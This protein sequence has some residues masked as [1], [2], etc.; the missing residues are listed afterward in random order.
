M[1]GDLFLIWMNHFIDNV[2]PTPKKRALLIL[3]GHSSH[4]SYEALELAKKRSVVL[5]CL[6]AHCTPRL[7]PLDVAFFGPLHK[8]YNQGVTQWLKQN[9]GRTVTIYQVASLFN[10]AYDKTATLEIALSGFRTTGISP[11]NRDI[12]PEHMF[13]PSLTTDVTEDIPATEEERLNDDLVDVQEPNEMQLVN[14]LLPTTFMQ[15]MTSRPTVAEPQPSA[16]IYATST[17]NSKKILGPKF[18]D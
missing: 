9:P 11:F 4:K 5:F 8:Y 2:R 18:I 1:T 10:K 7:Q 14:N 13:L 3:D 16:D 6:P 15:Q 17:S 12:F